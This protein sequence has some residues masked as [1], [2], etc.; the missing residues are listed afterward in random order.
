M[1]LAKSKG[2]GKL[3]VILKH[4]LRNALLP[5][6]TYAGPLIASLL[7]GSF[8]VETLFSIPGIGSEFVSSVTNRD[9]TLIMGLTIFMGFLVIVMSLV[10]DLVAAMVDPRIKL[11]K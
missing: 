3:M 4:G 1:V 7:T 6:V 11:D 10:S 2:T 9:Y 5:V 8:V